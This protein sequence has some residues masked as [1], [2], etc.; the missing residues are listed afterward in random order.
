MGG[1]SSLIGIGLSAP[2]PLISPLPSDAV[3]GEAA[4]LELTAMIGRAVQ[5]EG[6]DQP[7][8]DAVSPFLALNAILRVM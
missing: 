1:Q 2:R 7:V 8:R 3:S 6:M 5:T 4:A